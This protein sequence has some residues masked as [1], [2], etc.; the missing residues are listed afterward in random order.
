MTPRSWQPQYL[1]KQGSNLPRRPSPTRL[2]LTTWRRVRI[3]RT[4]RSDNAHSHDGAGMEWSKKCSVARAKVFAHKVSCNEATGL[5]YSCQTS[6]WPSENR[7]VRILCNI[8][9]W[10]TYD[11]KAQHTRLTVLRP[12]S[13]TW[14]IADDIRPQSPTSQTDGPTFTNTTSSRSSWQVS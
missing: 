8:S 4:L 13:P 6:K 2:K 14:Q 5:G 12:Q 7:R 10:Q 1:H 3:L 11:H 9:D